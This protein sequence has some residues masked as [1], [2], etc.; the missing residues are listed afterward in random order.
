MRIMFKVLEKSIIYP[1]DNATS[2]SISRL[3][4]IFLSVKLYNH[5]QEWNWRHGM[6]L[7]E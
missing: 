3:N 7:N 6:R 2:Q 1:L 5:P 4:N